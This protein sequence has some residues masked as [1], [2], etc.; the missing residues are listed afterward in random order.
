MATMIRQQHYITQ[1]YSFGLVLFLLAC[2]V[3]FVFYLIEGKSFKSLESESPLCDA[4]YFII[5]TGTTVGFGDILPVTIAAKFV[6]SFFIVFSFL[7]IESFLSYIERFSCMKNVSAGKRLVIYIVAALSSLAGGTVAFHHLESKSW[8]DSVYF[9]I[10]TCSTVGFGDFSFNTAEGRGFAILWL[11]FNCV[12]FSNLLMSIRDFKTI[13]ATRNRLKKEFRISE[14][15]EGGINHPARL[16]KYEYTL[17]ILKSLGRLD[18]EEMT[19]ISKKFDSY[20]STIS[21]GQPRIETSNLVP[22]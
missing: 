5:V 12:V 10:V 19:I 4:L 7:F 11:A 17:F 14:L 15:A 22:R 2:A 13:M 8:T 20:P 21:D 6:T 9:S 1:E 16:S 18:E 3:L